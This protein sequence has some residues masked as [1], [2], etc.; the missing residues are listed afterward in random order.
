M[1]QVDKDFLYKLTSDRLGFDVELVASI[2]NTVFKELTN[3]IRHPANLNIFL[4][5]LGTFRVRYK[6]MLPWYERLRDDKWDYI[7]KENNKF[8]EEDD[9]K[10][11]E[12]NRKRFFNMDFLMKQYDNYRE[13][14]RETRIA[15]DEH[16][17]NL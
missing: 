8:I 5:K 15:R 14:R 2:G 3:Q 1:A 11:Y 6:N 7:D 10:V 4:E 17:N 12:K 9:E 16:T 13:I